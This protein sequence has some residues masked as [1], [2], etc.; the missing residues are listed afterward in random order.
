MVDEVEISR[1]TKLIWDRLKTRIEPR[2]AGVGVTIVLR[3]E[4][5]TK[6]TVEGGVGNIGVIF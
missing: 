5:E 4:F 3:E 2:R 1:V 6:Y